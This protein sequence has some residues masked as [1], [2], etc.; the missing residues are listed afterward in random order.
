MNYK[1]RAEFRK[2]REWKA[3]KA[4]CR[5]H[6]S[7]DYITKEP[8]A[9]DWNLHHLDLNIHRYSDISDLNRFLPLNPKTHE[10]IHE[11]FKMYKKNK[12]CIDRI[13]EI[14]DKMLEYT[15]AD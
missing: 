11:L 14:L 8:L 3:F 4:K 2:S 1:E 5:L 12:N 6:V 13:K 7:V 15:N 9:K 10:V